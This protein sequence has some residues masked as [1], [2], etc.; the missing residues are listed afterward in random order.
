[1]AAARTERRTGA[2]RRALMPVR[3]TRAFAGATAGAAAEMAKA[4]MLTRGVAL[5]FEEARRLTRESARGRVGP[6]SD[7]ARPHR[8]PDE[9]IGGVSPVLRTRRDWSR[10]E[11]YLRCRKTQETRGFA[12]QMAVDV[13]HTKFDD[14]RALSRKARQRVHRR[15]HTLVA[16]E[17]ETHRRLPLHP[18]MSAL[19]HA[20]VSARAAPTAPRASRERCGPRAATLAEAAI[21]RRFGV[22]AA[23]RRAAHRA[24]RPRGVARCAG[25]ARRRAL[26]LP[27][28][29]VLREGER[30]DHRARHVRRHQPPRRRSGAGVRGR[31]HPVR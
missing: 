28:R 4:D 2:A 1:M 3:A 31:R 10:H 15:T 29:R 23:K 11:I 30:G 21:A 26:P 8:L 16:L 9:H 14:L 19:A 7:R 5:L 12:S 24:A 25:R 6:S 13:S 18:A 27:P 17:R 22:R 20:A